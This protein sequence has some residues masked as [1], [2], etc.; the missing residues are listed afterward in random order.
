MVDDAELDRLMREGLERRAEAVDVTAPVAR[1]ATTAVRRRQRGWLTAGFAAASVAAVAVIATLDS[2]PP[3]PPDD[4]AGGPVAVDQSGDWRTEYWADMKVDVP[5][6]WGYGGA[7]MASGGDVVS[8]F[9]EQ[10]LE[11]DGQRVPTNQMPGQVGYVGR[12]IGMT[13]VCVPYPDNRPDL[14]HVPY[15]WLGADVE[16]GTIDLGDG[17]VQETVEVNGST[18]TVA[19]TDAALRERIL[20]SAGGGEMCLSEIE[21]GGSIEHDGPLAAELKPTSMTVCAYRS[22][23]GTDPRAPATLAYAGRVGRAATDEYFSHV[24]VAGPPKDQCPAANIV[25]SEWVVLEMT[26]DDGTITDRHVVH[27][28]CPGIDLSATTLH[29]FETITLTPELARPWAVGGISAVIYGPT[30]GRGAMFDSFIG[31]QG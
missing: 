16:V 17:F 18:L 6:D 14:P 2:T 9:P 5:A 29:G 1:N 22:D 3:K 11:A 10:M 24:A 31:P 20:D 15:V 13:D 12:P 4:E 8:C 7:P 26:T 19:S 30:G 23:D 27:F 28:V 25:E 21:T